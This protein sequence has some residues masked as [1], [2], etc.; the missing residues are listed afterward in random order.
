MRIDVHN[1]FLPAQDDGC[2]DL[3]ES[4]VALRQMVAAGY[5]RLFCTPHT[6]AGTFSDPSPAQVAA[7]VAAL[8]TAVQ[9]A[10]IPLELKPGGELRLSVSLPDRLPTMELPTFGHAGKYVLID[11]WER[12]WPTWATRSV[13]WLG[14]QNLQVILAHPERMPMVRRNPAFMDEL[15][16]M[17]L[18]FQGNLGPIGGGDVPDIVALAHR[19][20]QDGRYFMLGTDGHRPDTLGVRIDGLQVVEHLA[21]HAKLTEL[22]EVNPGKLWESTVATG[23]SPAEFD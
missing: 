8:R 11:L 4:L 9:Q 7:A 1:H 5:D 17:G 23:P 13:E 2:R 22:T 16:K 12:D 20:L 15:T 21:G 6:N 3:A 14:A 10:G 19:F 18:W